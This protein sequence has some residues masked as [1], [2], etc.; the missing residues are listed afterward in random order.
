M[1]GLL[2]LLFVGV[3]LLELYILLQLSE[4]VGLAPTIG[5]VLVTGVVGGTLARWQGTR[6]L[7]DLVDAASTGRNP[8][9]EL[10]AGA[11]FVAGA[12]FL[13]T[14]GIVTD[15]AGF[16]LMVPA[17][18]RWVADHVVDR[19]EASSATVH[20]RVGGPGGVG[21][22]PGPGP[23]EAGGPKRV[24]A[25]AQVRPREEEPGEPDE[26]PLEPR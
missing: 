6:A 21:P 3:P 18:R 13:L 15:V 8:G 2:V 14:P 22:G 5:L 26:D 1:L 7:R 9:T 16:L 19:I 10:A 11:L 20:V 23:G 4:A 24:D 12:A 17:V 25:D